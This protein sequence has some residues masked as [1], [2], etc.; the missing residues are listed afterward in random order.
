MPR[1]DDSRWLANFIA[2]HCHYVPGDLMPLAEFADAFF[3]FLRPREPHKWT[4]PRLVRALNKIGSGFVY[5]PHN[6]NQ[7]FVGNMS[8]TYRRSTK[9][10]ISK[11]NGRLRRQRAKRM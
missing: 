6:D 8:W 11:R 9:P 4:K 7:R 10:P 2:D 3:D 1:D 5:G